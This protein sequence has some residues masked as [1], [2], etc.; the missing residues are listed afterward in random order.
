MIE[1]GN[2]VT[3]KAPVTVMPEIWK[4]ARLWHEA[5]EK[6]RYAEISMVNFMI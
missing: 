4:V 2:V 1:E 5:D 3:V 6:Y